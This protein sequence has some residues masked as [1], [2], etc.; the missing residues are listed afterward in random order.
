MG[1]PVVYAGD[2]MEWGGSRDEKA[3][4]SADPPK[5]RRSRELNILR[6]LCSMTN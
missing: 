3:K 5:N 6:L 4:D 1:E 2:E